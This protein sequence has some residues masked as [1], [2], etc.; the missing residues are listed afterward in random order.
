MTKTGFEKLNLHV[1]VR[2]SPFCQSRNAAAGSVRQLDPRH[3]AERPRIF[4][5]YMLDGRKFKPSGYTNGAAQILKT[6]GFKIKPNNHT[7]HQ[8]QVEGFY[9]HWVEKRHSL[10]YEVDGIVIKVNQIELQTRLGDVGREPRW[11]IA[12]KFPPVQATTLL[13]EIKISVGRTGTMNPYAVLEPVQIGGVTVKQ[14]TLHNEDD[15]LRKDVRE[16]DTVIVQRAGDVIPQIVGPV[17]GKRPQNTR[18]FSLEEKLK[19]RFSGKPVCPECGSEISRPEGEVMYYC[20]DAAC[21]AQAE[22][23]IEHFASREAMDIRGIGENL[24]V[25]L[26]RK[27]L[28]QDFADLYYLTAEDLMRLDNMGEKSTANIINAIK[29]SKKPPLE[30]LVYGLGI[31][32]VGSETAG[33]LVK[34]FKNLDRLMEAGIDKLS[35][36]P[37]IGP[38]IAESIVAF[39]NNPA[40]GS[41]KKSLNMPK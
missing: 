30:R 25:A 13:K 38:R 22:Q 21:P 41:S 32:H 29:G 15:I 14:A 20:P 7:L 39:F 36:I 23:R 10:P 27:G 34:Q 19:D 11:A 9:R 8:E 37:G 17:P 16:G 31:R 2:V 40:T 33:L 35:Q 3:H 6:W 26:F 5:F 24:S 12:F 1:P 4:I 28:V 18:P